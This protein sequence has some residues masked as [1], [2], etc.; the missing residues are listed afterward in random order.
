M[1]ASV[2]RHSALLLALYSSATAQM[3][4][5][6][7]PNVNS[8]GS[9]ATLSGAFGS[10]V[11]SGLHLEVTGGVP[12][13]FGY[14]AVGDQVSPAT[15]ISLGLLCLGGGGARVYRYN[16]SGTAWFSIG[17][18][19]A[20][21]TFVN[22]AGTSAIGTG[23]DVPNTIPDG[24]P[25]QILLGD[26]WHFQFWYRDSPA[27]AGSSNLSNGLS[28]TFHPPGTPIAGMIAIPA[29]T[30]QMGSN[31]PSGPPYFGGP[32]TQPVHT[33]TISQ[34]FWMSSTEV[35]QAQYQALMGGNPSNFVGANRP[36]EQVSWHDARAL[37]RRT[38]SSRAG[39]GERSRWGRVSV[40]H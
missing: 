14:F 9:A 28:V 34:N 2:L 32:Y 30:F 5:F 37:L 10:G 1:I 39:F 22:G 3:V 38:H 17:Q 12:N 19:N 24:V 20:A 21:G 23:F 18:F 35:T 31:A 13:E 36:V 33:V 29:G 6:C 26:T 7:P 11:G 25:S 4:T 8:T 40:A 27:Q 16:A 15:P